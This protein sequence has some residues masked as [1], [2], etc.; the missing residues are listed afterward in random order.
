MKIIE[1]TQYLQELINVQNTPDI[2]VITGIRRSGKSKLLEEYIKYIKKN[3]LNA[4]I[5]H[6]NFNNLEFEE[7]TEYHALYNYVKSNFNE[8]M[9]N[10]LFIDEIQMCLGFEKAINSLHSTENFNIFIT[11][12]KA[13]L[14]SSDLATLFTGRAFEIQVFPFSFKEFL[15]YNEINNFSVSNNYQLNEYL[16]LYIKQGGL[17][18]SYLYKTEEEKY[19]Y[20]NEEVF[21]ALIV[22][23]I[24]TK[25]RIRNILL[26][27]RLCHFLSSNIGNITSI[28]KITKT[29]ISSNEQVND[30]T[31]GNYID[32][33]LKAFSFYRIRR[34]DIKGKR[35]LASEDKYYLCDHSFK[36][37]RLG[38]KNMD[39]GSVL[40]NIVAIELLR[41]KY[42]VYV[43]VLYK[44]EI[45]FVA[46]NQNEKIYI[47]VS[48]DISNKDTFLREI[49][50]LLKIHD[51]YP[52]IL[53]ARTHTEMTQY[54]GIKIYD[55]AQWLCD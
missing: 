52:K 47:Q 23:D 4:N 9:Q 1:R 24:V 29:L 13:F 27:I 43:G 25:H 38:T 12:S 53:L 42:Q 7:L 19:R 37:A 54:E 46:I 31:I 6:I 8:K 22:R 3:N 51:A 30:K 17:S 26:L 14:M 44:K 32:Y 41:R 49:T 36:Y 50:P 21:N 11:G 18:G 35:Y 33:L 34:Y 48:D 16:A 45:D 39:F 2:K 5:I 20:I 55:I 15:I 28:R 40:E 10:F